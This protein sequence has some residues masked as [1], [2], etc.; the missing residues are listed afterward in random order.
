VPRSLGITEA[1]DYPPDLSPLISRLEYKFHT[2]LFHNAARVSVGSYSVFLQNYWGVRH[3]VR[4]DH[5]LFCKCPIIP[6]RW[7]MKEPRSGQFE[8][9]SAPVPF[10]SGLKWR[11]RWTTPLTSLRENW[12]LSLSVEAEERNIT[13]LVPPSILMYG[14]GRQVPTIRVC[15]FTFRGKKFGECAYRIQKEKNVWFFVGG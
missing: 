15:I 9:F 7:N 13:E 14:P 12:I 4:S 1:P 8:G 5:L 3:G 10:F 2:A 11:R 6:G